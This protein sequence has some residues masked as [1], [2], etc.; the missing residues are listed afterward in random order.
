MLFMLAK[1]LEVSGIITLA[2]AL[3]I[4]LSRQDMSAEVAL[5]GVGTAVFYLGRILEKRASGP[6]GS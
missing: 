5:L 3:Y 1:G 2:W 4:G 6:G